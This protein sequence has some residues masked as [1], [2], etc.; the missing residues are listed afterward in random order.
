MLWWHWFQEETD[1]R[2][3]ELQSMVQNV[4]HTEAEIQQMYNLLQDLESSMNN[5]KQRQEKV[6][7]EHKMCPPVITYQYLFNHSRCILAVRCYGVEV[8]QNINAGIYHCFPCNPFSMGLSS[9]FYIFIIT[10]RCSKQIPLPVWLT[11]V[12]SLRHVSSFSHVLPVYSYF[13]RNIGTH[14][15]VALCVKDALS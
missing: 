3:V 7:T 9:N 10:W 14:G 2:V 8:R 1:E 4:T 13:T 15:Q 5:T 6:W 11:R 12:I